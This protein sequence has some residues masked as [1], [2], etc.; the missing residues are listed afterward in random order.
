MN[1]T[2]RIEKPHLETIENEPNVEEYFGDW[3]Q[4]INK[5]KDQFANAEP[6]EHVV[7]ENFLNAEYAEKLYNLFP[8]NYEEWYNY[9]NPIEV[10]YA[11]D[12]INIFPYTLS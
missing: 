9:C 5:L 7:I 11:F 3:T 12:N 10:K 4:D 2:K 8:S 1:Y 6:F